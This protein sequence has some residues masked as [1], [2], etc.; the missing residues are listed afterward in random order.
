VGQVVQWCQRWMHHS[1]RQRVPAGLRLRQ[2]PGSCKE[3]TSRRYHHKA[4]LIRMSAPE[5]LVE[6]CWLAVSS[7]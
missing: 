4:G 1:H 7:G 3:P 5:T 6:H 2:L